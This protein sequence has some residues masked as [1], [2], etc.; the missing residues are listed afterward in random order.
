MTIDDLK[1]MYDEKRDEYGQNP[2]PTSQ[3]RIH[4]LAFQREY[5]KHTLM[6]PA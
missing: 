1:A 5:T 2:K 4:R 6:N 3:T